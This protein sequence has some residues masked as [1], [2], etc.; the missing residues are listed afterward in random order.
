MKGDELWITYHQASRVDLP[1]TAQLIKLEH[2][3][4]TLYDLED[5]LEYIFSQGF[6][7]AKYRSLTYWERKDG[8]PVKPSTIVEDLLKQGV[9]TCQETALR[10]IIRDIPA[11]LWFK[12]H[13]T[14]G[15]ASGHTVTQRVK[16]EKLHHQKHHDLVLAHVTNYIFDHGFVKAKLR[17][18]VFWQGIHGKR[19]PEEIE[20][21]ELLLAGQGV[22]EHKALTLHI[23][24]NNGDDNRYGKYNNGSRSERD[25]DDE[26]RP[27]RPIRDSFRDDDRPFREDR[28][29]RAA[30]EDK[31][32]VRLSADDF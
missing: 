17:S 13:F 21:R 27:G 18:K 29:L 22:T 23:D 7:E 20:L 9:G 32:R 30:S 19:I 24:D 11:G 28:P 5:V 31:P 14:S 3:E 26:G 2:H 16:L 1:S 10:L 8:G 15:N 25:Y 4:H 12:Y 6:I